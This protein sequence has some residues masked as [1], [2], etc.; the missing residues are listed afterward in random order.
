MVLH[1]PPK[2][3]DADLTLDRGAILL[4]NQKETGEAAVRLRF[5]GEVW[6]V[7]LA[8]KDTEVGVT[9]FS[10]HVLPYGS[11]EGP[12][13]WLLPICPQGAGRRPYYP[14]R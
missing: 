13:A 10:R 12:Q 4:T 8:E 5:R 3:F 1:A 2:D 7:R 6:D 14:V 11:G 9:L